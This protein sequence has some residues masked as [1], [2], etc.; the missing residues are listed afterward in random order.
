MINRLLFK[1]IVIVAMI[2]VLVIAVSSLSGCTDVP[3]PP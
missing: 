2:T 3:L 1:K